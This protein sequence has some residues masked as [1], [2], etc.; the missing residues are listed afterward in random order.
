[1]NNAEIKMS[2]EELKNYISNINDEVVTINLEDINDLVT[3]SFDLKNLI[4]EKKLDVKER[5]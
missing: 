1:M 5:K 4:M 3:T 2:L